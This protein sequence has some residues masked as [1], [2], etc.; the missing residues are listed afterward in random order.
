MPENNQSQ[1]QKEIA[2]S[3][4]IIYLTILSLITGAVV[5]F[6]YFK[7]LPGISEFIEISPSQEAAIKDQFLKTTAGALFL[8][9]L[10]NIYFWNINGQLNR[11]EQ[12]IRN[13][14][15]GNLNEPFFQ[16][17]LE[18][19]EAKR[20]RYNAFIEPIIILVLGAIIVLIIY[21]VISPILRLIYQVYPHT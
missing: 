19:I 7:V 15:A 10:I 3:P 18:E 2:G 8:V 21:T 6:I 9:F 12:K 14:L 17:K 20:K 16:G 4:R 13:N 5:V 1:S 11:E